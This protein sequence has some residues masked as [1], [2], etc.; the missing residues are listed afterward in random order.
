MHK[1]ETEPFRDLHARL[2]WAYDADRASD[3]IA[4]RDAATNTDLAR[5][6]VL[7]RTVREP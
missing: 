4:G 2:C 1:P 6:R 5:W 7:G 3:I